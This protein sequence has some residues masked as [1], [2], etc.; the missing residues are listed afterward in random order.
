MKKC[1]PGIYNCIVKKVRID[2]RGNLNL[3]FDFAN[4]KIKQVREK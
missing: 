3:I 4:K 1:K 2:R